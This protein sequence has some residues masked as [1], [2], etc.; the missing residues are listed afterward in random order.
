VS[1]ERDVGRSVAW[2]P[3]DP[4]CPRCELIDLVQRTGD[5]RVCTNCWT[6]FEGTYPE[7]QAMAGA[8]VQWREVYT[9]PRDDDTKERA[10]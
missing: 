4:P 8:R 5:Q 1:D 10:T 3:S 6:L 9:A 7:W 2:D